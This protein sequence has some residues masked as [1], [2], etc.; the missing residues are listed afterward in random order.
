MNSLAVFGCAIGSMHFTT[1]FTRPSKK[2][3]IFGKVGWRSGTGRGEHVRTEDDK[4]K[5]DEGRLR[6]EFIGFVAFR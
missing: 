3:G 2:C 6:A 4:G 5:D 1:L